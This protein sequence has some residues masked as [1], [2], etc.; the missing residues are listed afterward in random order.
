MTMIKKVG[1]IGCGTMGGGIVQGV[2]EA[3]DGV[4]VRETGEV[5]PGL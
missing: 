2:L 4:V 1:I 5:A 3:G